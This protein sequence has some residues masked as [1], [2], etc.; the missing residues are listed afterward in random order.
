MPPSALIM[1]IFNMQNYTYIYLSF[2]LVYILYIKRR[3]HFE[4]RCMLTMAK[5]YLLTLEI[6]RI[7]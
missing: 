4:I 7:K 2:E 5:S 1:A 6:Y 3:N